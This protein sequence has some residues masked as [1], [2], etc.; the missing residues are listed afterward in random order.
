MAIIRRIAISQVT[1]EV[2]IFV[3]IYVIFRPFSCVDQI[4]GIKIGSFVSPTISITRV[5]AY[6]DID[7]NYICWWR[8]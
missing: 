5:K 3:F 8:I 6:I 1:T 7:V 4:I 2:A